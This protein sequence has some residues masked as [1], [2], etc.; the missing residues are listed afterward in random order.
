MY[1]YLN[2]MCPFDSHCL[3]RARVP[4][5]VCREPDEG[6]FSNSGFKTGPAKSRPNLAK[7]GISKPDQAILAGASFETGVAE[8]ALIRLIRWE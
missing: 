6:L 4:L 5:T 3:L 8:R 7:R 1:V 2:A